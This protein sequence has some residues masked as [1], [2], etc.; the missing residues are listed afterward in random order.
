VLNGTHQILVY[1][2]YVYILGRRIH[3]VKTNTEAIVA[4]SKDIGL[5]VN[6]KKLNTWS[7]LEIRMQDEV[8]I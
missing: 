2:D 3:T 1:A 5:E 6:A 8:T 7:C 4:A